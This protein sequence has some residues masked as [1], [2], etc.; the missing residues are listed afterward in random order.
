MQLQRVRFAGLEVGPG[1]VNPLAIAAGRGRSWRSLVSILEDL[2]LSTDI[3]W[4]DLAK[5]FSPQSDLLAMG[6]AFAYYLKF[7]GYNGICCTCGMYYDPS[8]HPPISSN[9]AA[10]PWRTDTTKMQ[11]LWEPWFLLRHKLKHGPGAV[12]LH[13]ALA[14]SQSV[15]ASPQVPVQRCAVMTC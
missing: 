7:E 1:T 3:F 11:P 14:D 10:L 15:A 8:M 2:F 13:F 12:L 9:L 5:T 4:A 6:Y